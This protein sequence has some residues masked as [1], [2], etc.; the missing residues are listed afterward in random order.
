[1]LFNNKISCVIVGLG[2]MG[3]V[4]YNV[5][6]KLNLNLVGVC[7]LNESRKKNLKK[8]DQKFF[9]KSFDKVLRNKIDLLI[10][11]STSD[12]HAKYAKKAILQGVKNILVEKPVV[13]S[14][15][16]G[17]ELIRLQKKYKTRI[18]VNHNEFLKTH[19]NILTKFIKKKK[20]IGK[21]TSIIFTGGN[22]GYAMNGVHVFDLIQILT[23]SKISKVLNFFDL[24]KTKNPR[25]RK[26]NDFSG[27]LIGETKNKIN[28]FIDISH[29]QGHGRNIKILFEYGYIDYD[30]IIGKLSYNIRKKK[31]INLPKTRYS[32]PGESG[33]FKFKSDTIEK[34]TLL[35]LKNFL[36]NKSYVNLRNGFENVK[37][38]I[39]AS[40]NK[41]IKL[42]NLNR[43]KSKEKFPW[44]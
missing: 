30:Y 34:V 19:I 22:I 16:D 17:Y 24:K 40:I 10:I 27:R 7:D 13:T 43:I 9:T 20:Y 1:M 28:F 36:T 11:S 4:Y 26:F 18:C 15:K 37:I 8:K 42:T 21:I 6:R 3:L 41:N 32:T 25:G 14:L 12:Y 5:L 39:A 2:K 44:A 38:L 31:F 29:N 33:S 35:H 23:R